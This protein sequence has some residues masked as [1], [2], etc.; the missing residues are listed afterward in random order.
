MPAGSSLNSKVRARLLISQ[1]SYGVDSIQRFI[2]PFNSDLIRLTNARKALEEGMPDRLARKIKKNDLINKAF[3]SAFPEMS[4]RRIGDLPE[5]EQKQAYIEAYLIIKD[6]LYKEVYREVKSQ[7][8]VETKKQ[9]STNLFDW[10]FDIV[11]TLTG[12]LSLGDIFDLYASQSMAVQALKAGL[13]QGLGGYDL[14]NHA[15]WATFPEMA[16]KAIGNVSNIF[17]RALYTISYV[18]I[19]NT[20]FK[21]ITGIRKGKGSGSIGVGMG[22]E[23][24]IKSFATELGAFPAQN[25]DEMRLLIGN[26]IRK[27]G[28]FTKVDYDEWTSAKVKPLTQIIFEARHSDKSTLAGVPLRKYGKDE[29]KS[30]WSAHNLEEADW[31]ELND[32]R[33]KLVYPVMRF[34]LPRIT[35][36][37]KITESS[38]LG[39]KIAAQAYDYLGLKY[40]RG[41]K[42]DPQTGEGSI[43]C[44]G[45]VGSVF[46]DLGLR[47]KRGSGKGGA[48]QIFNSEQLETVDT[49][50]TGDLLFRLTKDGSRYRHIGIYLGG[51]EIIHAPHSGTV[52]RK[53]S[54]DSTKWDAIRRYKGSKP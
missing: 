7:K 14:F 17:N 26:I 9:N 3:W 29:Y 4:D 10:A 19:K 46:K 15:F 47:L 31:K 16:G 37:P 2:I 48:H 5:G 30:Q 52:V 6:K 42:V 13:A 22:A 33:E 53:E 51:D 24:F 12:G 50:E 28:P 45:M 21:Q 32:I 54:Y 35:P 41:G 40:E 11:S 43:D 25:D 1:R 38:T 20:I 39:E 23:E 34:V 8:K 44:S 18:F 49:A 36:R 27:G